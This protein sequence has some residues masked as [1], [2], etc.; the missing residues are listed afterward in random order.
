MEEIAS[1]A[2]FGGM[3]KEFKKKW[4]R[5]QTNCCMLPAEVQE[6]AARRKLFVEAQDEVLC[7]FVRETDCSR[8]Y[9]Y[10]KEDAALPGT[11]GWDRPV[12]IDCVFR[13]QEDAAL[14]KCGAE[15]WRARGFAPYKR[16]RRM[17]CT[18][19]RFLPPADE[20]EMRRAFPVVRL[21][22]ED[23]EGV[24]RLWRG[25]L[26]C[27]SVP[28]WDQEEFAGA[29]GRGEILGIRLADG[30]VGTVITVIPRGKTSFMEH[31][32]VSR[33][34]RGRG[35]GRTAFC[36]ASMQL[37]ETYG[38]E[39]INFWVEETNAH[40]IA[41]YERMGYVY[42]GTVSRQFLLGDK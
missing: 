12:V 38:A 35:M 26:D 31:L 13:G 6:L 1:A 5:V 22:P 18:R 41:I 42:D 19:E 10:M 39:K 3:V 21:A 4:G 37:F 25:S 33:E 40:A 20:E 28:F 17:E 29:C 36:G 14:E 34:L 27:R 23:Y 30:A 16:N 24:S 9:Y 7:F 15:R 2:Q 8:L 32:V 11:E